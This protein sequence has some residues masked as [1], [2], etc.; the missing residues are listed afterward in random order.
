MLVSFVRSTW[1]AVP[2]A[3]PTQ[4]WSS[5]PDFSLWLSSVISVSNI[6]QLAHC[7]CLWLRS[8]TGYSRRRNARSVGGHPLSV[9][10]SCRLWKDTVEL[11]R[12]WIIHR[13]HKLFNRKGNVTLDGRKWRKKRRESFT[14]V[15]WWILS[16]KYISLLIFSRP[17]RPIE[18]WRHTHTRTNTR[19]R[20]I[21]QNGQM[22]V[23]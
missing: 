5:F 9:W 10:I 20:I 12:G 17:R 13:S 1:S 14:S 22:W 2:G 11:R 7:P 23:Y 18:T 19:S 6:D 4:Y 21:W 8:A 3:P 16:H 15:A